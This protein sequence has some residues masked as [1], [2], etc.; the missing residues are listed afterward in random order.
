MAEEDLRKEIRQLSE[1]MERL[2]KT[3]KEIS[4]PYSQVLGYL[5]RFQEISR[6]YFKLLEMYE[7]YGSV[8]PEVLLPGLKDPISIEIIKILFDAKE[9]NISEITRELKNRRG[10]ASRR[11]VRERLQILEKK[12]AIEC[13]STG[14][15]KKYSISQELLS[16]WSQVLALPKYEGHSYEEKR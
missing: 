15:S 3:I 12:G 14:K 7:R 6:G 2:E 1:K 10:T 5:E 4:T 13:A 16:R 11:I 8:S 9:R